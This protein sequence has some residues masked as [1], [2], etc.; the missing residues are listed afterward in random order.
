LKPRAAPQISAVRRGLRLN[1]AGKG[2][3]L[4]VFV[5]FQSFEGSAR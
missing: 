3:F 5:D 4:A 2:G 1:D